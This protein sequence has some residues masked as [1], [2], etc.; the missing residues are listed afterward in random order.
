MAKEIAFSEIISDG[1]AADVAKESPVSDSK[2]PRAVR[3][4]NRDPVETRGK[5]FKSGMLEPED[6]SQAAENRWAKGQSIP[7]RPKRG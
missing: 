1:H 6:T 2:S 7:E 5:P 4:G 3:E